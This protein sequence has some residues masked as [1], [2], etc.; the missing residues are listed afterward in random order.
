[1]LEILNSLK[2][3]W[4]ALDKRFSDSNLFQSY[5]FTV[6]LLPVLFSQNKLAKLLHMTK[7]I[8][9]K[10]LGVLLAFK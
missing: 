8:L 7:L 9:K 6:V 4:I 10:K 1:M 2:E 3:N 5:N